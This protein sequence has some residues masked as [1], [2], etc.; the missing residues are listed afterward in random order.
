MHRAQLVLENISKRR[1]RLWVG[2]IF[3]EHQWPQSSHWLISQCPYL[4]VFSFRSVCCACTNNRINYF[5][6]SFHMYATCARCLYCTVT[7]ITHEGLQPNSSIH[8]LNNA[9]KPFIRNDSMVRVRLWPLDF[10]FSQCFSRTFFFP[11][12]SSY[13]FYT[14]MPACGVSEKFQ[15]PT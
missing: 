4:H 13:L 9:N 3:D 10:A 11:S 8:K 6:W 7:N 5:L 2:F 1:H 14:C 15:S 12:L